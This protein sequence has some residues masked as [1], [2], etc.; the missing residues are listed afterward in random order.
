MSIPEH[1]KK[2]LL[3]WDALMLAYLWLVILPYFNPGRSS[4]TKGTSGLIFFVINLMFLLDYIFKLISL[5]ETETIAYTLSQRKPWII[6]QISAIMVQGFLSWDNGYR[7]Y[8]PP[9]GWVNDKDTGS[10]NCNPCLVSELLP[11]S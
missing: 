1:I 5:K 2:F 11:M 9:R 4:Q 7:F 10:S 8:P 3:S 6:L